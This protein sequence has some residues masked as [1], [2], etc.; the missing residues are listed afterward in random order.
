MWL[1]LVDRPVNRV[2]HDVCA[3]RGVTYV[4]VHSLVLRLEREDV[5]GALSPSLSVGGVDVGKD[6]GD[7]I[8]ELAD[9][10][11]VLVE[12][13]SAVVLSV[14]VPVSLKGVIAVDRDRELDAVAVRLHHKVVKTI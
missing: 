12:V 7:T 10:I 8:L 6:M 9:G 4:R 13:S 3:H 14:E 1:A 2:S 11:R 5:L